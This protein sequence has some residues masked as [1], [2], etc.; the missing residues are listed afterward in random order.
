MKIISDSTF[1]KNLIPFNRIFFNSGNKFTTIGSGALGGKAKSLAFIHN[2][3]ESS[4]ELKE[5]SQIEISIPNL[6][7][8]RTDVFDTF[9]KRN[10]LFDT[11]YSDE[12]DDRI[13]NAFQKAVLP[14]E[15]IGDLRALVSEVHTPLAIRS[16]SMLEDAL[17]EPFAG[18]YETKMIPNNQH[19]ADTRFQ[20]LVEAIKFVYASTFFRTAKDYIRATKHDPKEEK[21][22]VIIQEVIGQRH[23]DRFYPEISGV[24]C[25][26]NFYPMGRATP[27]QGVVNLA[28]GLGKTI[29]DGGISWTYSPAYPKINPPFGSVNEF[30]KNTQTKL[31][32]VNMGKPPAYDPIR[33]TEYLLQASIQDAEKDETLQNLASSYDPQ[34]DR[35]TIGL[36]GRGPRILTFAPLLDLEILPLNK[37]LKLLLSSCEEALEAS[38]EIEFAMTFSSTSKHRFGFLQVRPMVVST[39]KVEIKEADLVDENILVASKKVLGNGVIQDIQDVVYVKPD[40]FNAAN[41]PRIAAEIATFN[42]KLVSENR[43]YLLIGFGRW[44]SSEPWLGIPVN[45]GQVSGAKVIVEATLPNMN[46]DLSQGSHFFHNLTSFQ[47]SYF[48][49][50]FTSELKID[51]DWLNEHETIGESQF[52]CHKKLVHPLNVKVNGKSG[53]GIIFKVEHISVN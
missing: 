51:W 21:M 13:A 17:Y 39:E 45:W 52:V 12:P 43:S 42:R 22:A 20:K 25:S 46:V 5:F 44:G 18:I 19:N 11:A 41:T 4:S 33:E 2:F 35:I 7:V 50:P 29:V 36:G 10:N 6:T 1:G 48:S 37:L 16:S 30:L 26:Y 3:L 49:V 47:V 14:I 8:I 27:K 23:E 53:R 24:A 38:V 31:W 40:V 9:L 28:L 32:A 34:S 15:I